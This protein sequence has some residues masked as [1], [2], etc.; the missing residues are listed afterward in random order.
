MTIYRI[1]MMSL[2]VSAFLMGFACNDAWANDTNILG[3]IGLNTVP[4]ARVDDM[5]TMRLGLGVSEPYAH[6]FLGL[7]IAKPLYIQLRQTSQFE[8]VK[9]GATRLYPGLDF[10]YQLF[11][12]T[13][14]RPAM[15][16]GIN[17][18]LGHKKMSSE[19]IVASKRKGDFD[20]TLG[21]AWGRLAG[22]GHLKNPLNAIS[23]H[24]RESRDYNSESAQNIDDWFTGEEIG[25]FGGVQYHTP[26]KG[27][28]LKGDIGGYDYQNEARLINSYDAPSP[29]SV[30]FNYTPE[31]KNYKPASFS[32]GI[33]GGEQVFAR[34]SFQGN[35]KNYLGRGARQDAPTI[36]HSPRRNYKGENTTRLDL[37]SYLPAAKQIGRTA[38]TLSNQAYPDDENL[39]IA[40]R[41]KNIVGPDITI[42]RANLENAVLNKTSSPEEIWH[43]ATFTDP[44]IKFLTFR[45]YLNEYPIDH[46]ESEI[47]FDNKLSLSEDDSGVLFRNAL[48]FNYEKI[49]PWGL[50]AGFSPRFN[51]L[52]NTPFKTLSTSGRQDEALFANNPVSLDKAYLSWLYSINQ[53]LHIQSTIGYLEEQYAGVGGEVLYRP[54]GKRYAIGAQGWHV[55][56]RNPTEPMATELQDESNF[57]GHANIFYELPNQVTTVF[58]KAGQYLDNDLG[59][60][61]GIQNNFDNGVKLKAFAT[62][63]NKKD[64][65]IFGGQTSLY[66]GLQLTLPIGNIPFIPENTKTRLTVAPIARRTGQILDTPNKLYELTEPVSYRHLSQ[67]WSHLLD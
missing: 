33:I 49:L 63:T 67:S 61:I 52:S 8:N 34:L 23:S 48:I 58:V 46:Y 19:Y 36:I 39:F 22:K 12:E 15:A 37:T 3:N 60:T 53:H 35:L 38:R 66:G 44:K 11:S 7:Q 17:S 62:A 13:K 43:S 47:I 59:G 64:V 42:P 24:F 29:W 21:T 45:D 25:F 31:F 26:F 4:S 28:S 16:L 40:L 32:A 2:G 10:K 54:F 55:K 20:F 57:T 18:A 14:N 6:S 30:G 51:L 50:Q 41:Y 9:D 65:S 5:G 56:K 27:L 1:T